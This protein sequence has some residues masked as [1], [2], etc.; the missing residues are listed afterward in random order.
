MH[1]R[2]RKRG[3]DDPFKDPARGAEGYAIFD[4]EEILAGA[5]AY[6]LKHVI[7]D[8]DNGSAARILM[9][10]R[11]AM[12]ENGRLLIVE[13]IYPS[14][15]DPSFASRRA[16]TSDVNMPVSTGGRQRSE[17]EFRALYATAGFALRSIVPTQAGISIIEGVRS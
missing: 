16:F 10:C 3:L 9:N 13:G 14:R 1:G 7:H 6:I 12:P 15:A 2:G 5:D 17:G 11:R 4:A 8:W